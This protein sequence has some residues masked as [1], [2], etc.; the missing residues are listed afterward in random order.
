MMWEINMPKSPTHGEK[1]MMRHWSAPSTRLPSGYCFH[2]EPKSSSWQ[3]EEHCGNVAVE[4]LSKA[5]RMKRI[6]WGKLCGKTE[7]QKPSGSPRTQSG[8]IL[9]SGVVP[10]KTYPQEV[11]KQSAFQTVIHSIIHRAKNDERRCKMQ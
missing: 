11:R 7:E 2:E 6:A 9:A 3:A 10:E 8:G 1:R 4:N 5:R